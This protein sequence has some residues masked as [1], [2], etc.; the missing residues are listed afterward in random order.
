MGSES[1]GEFNV[2]SGGILAGG[3]EVMNK[4]MDLLEVEISLSQFVNGGVGLEGS[5]ERGVEAGVSEKE[6]EKDIVIFIVFLETAREGVG[7]GRHGMFISWE[8]EKMGK[9]GRGGVSYSL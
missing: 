7:E 1:E 2:W 3:S 8:C 4:L 9:K 5:T 6:R